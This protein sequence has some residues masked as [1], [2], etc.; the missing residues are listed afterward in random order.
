MGGWVG[1][2]GSDSGREGGCLRNCLVPENYFS[3][4][5]VCSVNFL[6]N[7]VELA[8]QYGGLLFAVEHRYYGLSTFEDYLE[9]ENLKYLSS[10]QA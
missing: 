8:E 3:I 4:K 1:V 10:Q 5:V 6:G 7:I 2:R 9:T